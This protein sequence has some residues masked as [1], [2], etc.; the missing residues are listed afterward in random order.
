[1]SVTEFADSVSGAATSI[2]KEGNPFIPEWTWSIRETEMTKASQ[3]VEVEDQ[4]SL[5]DQDFPELGA[6]RQ[7][8]E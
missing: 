2:V 7:C 1:M 3:P 4:G 5:E 6:S 8:T